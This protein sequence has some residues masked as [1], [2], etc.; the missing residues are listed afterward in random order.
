MTTHIRVTNYTAQA[1]ML[2]MVPDEAYT[3]S[4]TLRQQLMVMMFKGF[5]NLV[6]NLEKS[7]SKPKSIADI[8]FHLGLSESEDDDQFLDS[9][10]SY[11]K[12]CKDTKSKIK[13]GIPDTCDM[14]VFSTAVRLYG[15]LPKA[16][17]IIM[18]DG[19]DLLSAFA[20]EL[21]FI[22]SHRSIRE[23][24]YIILKSREMFDYLGSADR[25]KRKTGANL[26]LKRDIDVTEVRLFQLF[27]FLQEPG[28]DISHAYGIV[29]K[30]V[31]SSLAKDM[32]L[33]HAYSRCN[34][35]GNSMT[36]FQLEY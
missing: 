22:E 5:K 11:V 1:R 32:E 29:N 2:K 18:S 10:I 12:S 31:T 8:V 6:V 15:K 23:K 14:D 4:L 24:E 28:V 9:I 16:C 34:L 13:I 3:P 33:L 35:T 20:D 17:P 36:T 25:L 30:A 26:V 27:P 7:S 21:S 19:Q